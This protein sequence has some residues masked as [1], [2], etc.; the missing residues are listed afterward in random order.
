MDDLLYKLNVLFFKFI[1]NCFFFIAENIKT[2]KEVNI[3]FW[4]H[5]GFLVYLYL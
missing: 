5:N 2:H 1:F 4:V 3:Q